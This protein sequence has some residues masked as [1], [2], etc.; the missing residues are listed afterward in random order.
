MED[1]NS[2][3]TWAQRMPVRRSQPGATNIIADLPAIKG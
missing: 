3:V 1:D 2:T